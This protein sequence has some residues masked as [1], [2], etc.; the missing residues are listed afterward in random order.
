[1][2][3]YSEPPWERGRPARNWEV[4]R[5]GKMHAHPGKALSGLKLIADR[6]G[7]HTRTN[8]K[9]DREVISDI[10]SLQLTTG[11]WF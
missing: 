3:T 10:F 4:R 5:A 9:P 1:M 8:R 2:L 11:L 7:L 6:C